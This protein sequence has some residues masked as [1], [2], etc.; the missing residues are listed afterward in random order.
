MGLRTKL[1]K[2]PVC[3]SSAANPYF[4]LRRRKSKLLDKKIV[5]YGLFDTLGTQYASIDDMITKFEKQ[6]TQKPPVK[7][8]RR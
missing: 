6:Q 3:S 7:H 1:G 5:D 8:R 2:L 4:K